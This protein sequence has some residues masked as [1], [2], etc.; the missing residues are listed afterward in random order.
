[1]GP[2]ESENTI[3]RWAA[4][5]A[6]DSK[7]S[8]TR[9]MFEL[10]VRLRR[11]SA[12]P[13]YDLSLGNPHLEPPLLWRDAVI[14]MLQTEPPG[15][16]RYMPNAGFPWVRE[17]VAGRER[18][19][20][21][22]PVTTDDVVMT[23]GAAGGMAIT[24]R[25]VLDPGD[26]II[27]PAPYFPDYEHYARAAYATL[28]TVRTQ[29]DFGLDLGA[30]ERAMRPETRVVV[31][32]SPNNPTGALYG[33]NELA[34]LAELL[35]RVSASRARPVY[36]VEDSPYRDLVYGG[37]HANS[38]LSHYDDVIHISSHSKDLG[39][40]GERIGFAF[41]SPRARGRLLLQRALPFAN[42]VLGFVSAP[43]IM[44]RALPLVLG[45]PG[46]HVDTGVYERNAAAFV[47]P[48]RA[49]GFD[50][51]EPRGGLFLFP[52]VPQGWIDA[53]GEKAGDELADR[54][55][56]YRT[57]VVPGSAFG[58]HRY[59]R[60]ALCVDRPEIEGALG[61]FACVCAALGSASAGG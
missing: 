48:L 15:Q 26:E 56:E 57:L 34:G 37:A 53:F 51:V 55:A 29:A 45:R 11:E 49:L 21:G 10:G 4:A 18:E 59:I 24:F 46:G 44:Q 38:I 9:K 12:A 32:N 33:E 3:S 31:I 16:H 41:I 20:F 61:A 19:R 52:R 42:R 28:V 5:G 60:I 17:F 23:V 13:V 43:A 58:A 47:A 50:I 54:L 25:S 39:L 40:A 1:M 6:L 8:A 36:V 7:D 14:H 22:V 35:K 30:I 27:V 2:M